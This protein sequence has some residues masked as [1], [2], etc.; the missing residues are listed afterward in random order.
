MIPDKRSIEQSFSRAAKTYDQSAQFQRQCAEDFAAWLAARSSGTP[1]RILEAGCGTG[2]LTIRLHNLYPTADFLAT[3][4]SSGMIRLC[5]ERFA[6]TP[7]RFRIH[8]FDLPFEISDRDLAVSSL[9]LQWSRNLRTAF[10][11]FHSALRSGGELFAA[12]PLE[13]SLSQIRGFFQEENTIFRGPR[14]PSLPEIE[15]ALNGLFRNLSLETS[16]YTEEYP[17][18]HAL[19]RSMHRNGTSG[20]NTGTPV[21]VLKE[22]IR[23][24]REPC[25]A[26]YKVVFLKGIRT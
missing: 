16:R 13:E 25:P 11:H 26:E 2:Q 22:L 4:L 18:L 3:D 8:D 6:G 21:S 1:A 7:I 17:D 14:L 15:Q 23:K 10:E 12:I 24:H 5:S 20:G 9:S 19:L